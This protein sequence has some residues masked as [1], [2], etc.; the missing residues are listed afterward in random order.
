MDI[1]DIVG[2]YKFEFPARQPDKDVEAKKLLPI[3]IQ[4]DFNAQLM[5]ALPLC[6]LL[7]DDFYLEWF[8]ENYVE[9]FIVEQPNST[10]AYGIFD[11]LYYSSFD[12]I[13]P[14][15]MQYSYIGKYIMD[16]VDDIHPILKDRI[17]KK[18]YCVI[19]L[20]E[21]YIKQLNHNFNFPHEFLIYGYDNENK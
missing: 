14:R 1:N 5:Y 2:P 21:Y 18:Y 4:K 8:Y 16:I 10:F 17:D 12:N 15:I 7:V 9:L 6:V 11:A 13:S 3:N 20:D 19:F